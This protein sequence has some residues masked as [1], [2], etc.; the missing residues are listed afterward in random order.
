MPFFRSGG[1]EGKSSSPVEND[2]VSNLGSSPLPSSS[3]LSPDAAPPREESSPARVNR[4]GG[5]KGGEDNAI[6]SEPWT[7]I[8]P[9]AFGI[10]RSIEDSPFRWCVRESFL[11]GVATGTM[12]GL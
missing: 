7:R 6:V 11:W 4:G 1:T 5:T 10:R 8:F 12:M 3:S 9:E 2:N